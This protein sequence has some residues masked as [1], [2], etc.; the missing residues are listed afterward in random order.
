MTARRTSLPADLLRS[1]LSLVGLL[2]LLAGLPLVLYVAGRELVP[3]GLDGLASPADLFS[4]Q[5]TG[6]LAL[7]VLTGIGWA[8][9]ASFALAVLLEVPAQLRGRSAPRLRGLRVSQR[10]AGALVGGVLVLLPTAGGAM[11]AQTV[12]ATA[13]PTSVSASSVP[14]DSGGQRSTQGAAVK[15][16]TKT[17]HPTYTV[18]DSRPADSLWS[19]AQ[20]RL[21]DGERWTEIAALNEGRTMTDGR[22]FHAADPIQP[23]WVLNLP[24]KAGSSARGVGKS[25]TVHR[26]DTLSRIAEEQLGDAERY[27][28]LVEANTGRAMDEAGHRLTDPDLILPGWKVVLPAQHATPPADAGP[29]DSDRTRPTPHE[30]RNAGDQDANDQGGAGGGGA[31]AGPTPGTAKPTQEA[32]PTQKAPSTQE[33]TP[34]QKATPTREA[35]PTP[36]AKPT[37]K[38]TPT[39][40]AKPTQKAT[41][42]PEAKPTQEATGA[43]ESPKHSESAAPSSPE[44]SESPAPS[45]DAQPSVPASATGTV[46][47]SSP[48]DMAALATWGGLLAAGLLSALTVKRLLQ[49]RRRRG[50]EHIALPRAVPAS[51][52]PRADEQKDPLLL[53]LAEVERRMRAT[54]APEGV[55]LVDRA[56]RTLAHHATAAGRSL[57]DLAAARL[58]PA[59]L[60]L[61]LNTPSPPLPPF[62][63]A[64]PDR[65]TLAADGTG[66][67]TADACR[68]VCAPY[69]ALVTL[70]RDEDD[71]LVLADLEA[72][73]VLLLPAG[74]EASRPILRALAIELATASW[75]DD[76]GVLLS[77]LGSGLVAIE[78]GFGRLTETDDPAAAV[79]EVSAWGRTVRTALADTGADSVRAARSRPTGAEAWTPRIALCAGPLPAEVVE[80]ARDLLDAPACA[81][82]ITAADA[83]T[84]P[85]ATVLPGPEGGTVRLAG[86]QV[87]LVPQHITDADYEAL[88]KIF[89]ITAAPA[90]A[91]LP[92]P[93]PVREPAAPAPDA[94]PVPNAA[95][96]PDAA[97]VSD[98]APVPHAAPAPIPVPVP[99]PDD[100]AAVEIP[101]PYSV[102]INLLGTPAVTGVRQEIAPA[103]AGRLTE[104]AAWI[105]LHPGADT[106]ALTAEIWPGGVSAAFRTAQLS[107]LRRWLGTDFQRGDTYR[108]DA[109]TGTDW[110]RF[111]AL[112]RRGRLKGDDGVEDLSA[113]LELVRGRPFDAIPPRRYV[114][115]EYLRQDMITAVVD[116][117]ALLAGLLVAAGEHVAAREA[118]DKG[119]LVEPAAERLHRLAIRAAD[120]AGDS[121][122]V[123]RYAHRIDELT[124]R[125]GTEMQPETAELLG[126]MALRP[127]LG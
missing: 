121:E 14:G 77:G 97:P 8:G 7:L 73:G 122:A 52:N 119:L 55:D 112:A 13:A 83:D 74:P 88:L 61:W 93:K 111:Q 116:T 105:A 65:W 78:E 84:L 27:P 48:V 108:F 64:G 69:P 2:V 30:D 10:M 109:D 26:G 28:D 34:T 63:A 100:A 21:G 51:P 9:W 32:E 4:R 1:L 102:G 123:E 31:S 98:A 115:A 20:E 35:K 87:R 96:V 29:A 80:A 47:E 86:R 5:D 113:A 117:A 22:T 37:Q 95:P 42:T 82:L 91:P 90:S 75:S 36:E 58:T 62:T 33:A 70:G 120:L 40:V 43:A 44:V 38:A 18:R 39:P 104:I 81:A 79:S 60:E 25:V 126:E 68:E 17:S 92:P 114:W 16:G 67:L 85:G 11:A 101:E 46:S 127:S 12:P 41:P 107:A 124:D 15:T 94:A 59:A 118:A 49:Q 99:V 45:R 66:L 71:A 106:A 72:L 76:L 125:L 53:Q 24:G 50:G 6:G 3:L 57:P 54:E 110:H 103:A 23:G 56:L 19:I 89:G